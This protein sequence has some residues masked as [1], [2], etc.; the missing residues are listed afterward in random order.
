MGD[1]VLVCVTVDDEAMDDSIQ[2]DQ[3][4]DDVFIQIEEHHESSS[5]K[6]YCER[7]QKKFQSSRKRKNEVPLVHPISSRPKWAMAAGPHAF[8]ARLMPR[9]EGLMPGGQMVQM[10]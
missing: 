4:L 7:S 3:F 10:P 5:L 8:Q 9:A 6:C 1:N 2:Y